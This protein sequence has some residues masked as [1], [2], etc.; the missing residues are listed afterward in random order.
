MFVKSVR[1]TALGSIVEFKMAGRFRTVA[2]LGLLLSSVGLARPAEAATAPGWEASDRVVT[3]TAGQGEAISNG[4][5]SGLAVTGIPANQD[6]RA[7]TLTKAANGYEANLWFGAPLRLTRGLIVSVEYFSPSG[8]QVLSAL[9]AD[10][11]AVAERDTS[12]GLTDVVFVVPVVSGD[13]VMLPMPASFGVGPDWDLQA[14]VVQSNSPGSGFH[15]HTR[16]VNVGALSGELTGGLRFGRTAFA[17]DSNGVHPGQRVAFPGPAGARPQSEHLVAGGNRLSLVV[18]FAGPFAPLDRLNG[19]PVRQDVTI[20]FLPT[21]G[22]SAA[23][24]VDWKAGNRTAEFDQVTS[25]LASPR[26]LGQAPVTVTGNTVTIDLSTAASSAFDR[27]L[28]ATAGLPSGPLVAG[29]LIATDWFVDGFATWL[30]TTTPTTGIETGMFA[31][32]LG[33]NFVPP[34]LSLPAAPVTTAPA[35][36]GRTLNVGALIGLVAGVVL[37]VGVAVWQIRR[38]RGRGRQAPNLRQNDDEGAEI[39]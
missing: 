16:L 1:Q 17:I 13:H 11:K 10:G 38:R 39:A 9:T 8:D 24:F 34:L 7:A 15:K 36:S 18:D 31:M 27:A 14:N 21:P 28:T 35:T 29:R 2:A 37:L 33:Q 32:R 20:T 4:Q 30:T 12:K 23:F 26:T 3:L 22:A 19:Q 25:N 6:L 5:V